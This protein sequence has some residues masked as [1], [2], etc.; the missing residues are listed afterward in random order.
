[1]PVPAAPPLIG[2]CP[3]AIGAFAPAP[4]PA[5]PA[6]FGTLLAGMPVRVGGALA[7]IS[8]ALGVVTFGLLAAMP[9]VV[10]DGLRG[11]GVPEGCGDGGGVMRDIDEPRFVI[12]DLR[13]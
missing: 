6:G 8:G 2:C 11:S 10:E 7:P 12:S 13:S 4:P 3:G 5:A 9:G 1:M